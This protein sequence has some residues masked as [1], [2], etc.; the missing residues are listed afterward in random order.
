MRANHDSY[1]AANS[2]VKCDMCYFYC[3]TNHAGFG[4]QVRGKDDTDGRITYSMQSEAVNQQ[5]LMYLLLAYLSIVNTP[6]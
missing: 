5:A 3:F 1:L 2:L 4:S 6:Q